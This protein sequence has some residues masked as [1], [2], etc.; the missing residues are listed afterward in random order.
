MHID[1]VALAGSTCDWGLVPGEI[2]HRARVG[3]AI[4]LASSFRKN[5]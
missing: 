5:L 4:P 1:P 3:L 2:T